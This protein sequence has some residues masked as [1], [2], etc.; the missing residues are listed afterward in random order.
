[1]KIKTI[2]YKDPNA[3]QE[4][5]KSL[6]ETGF[7]V[8][9]NHN[10][11]EDL[12]KNVY[13]DWERF[14]KS[15]DK[16]KHTFD[17]KV[18]TGYFPFKSENSKD[19]KVKDLKEFF[20]V[21]AQKDIPVELGS[22]TWELRTQLNE[23]G[24]TVLDWIQNNLPK[25]ITDKFSESLPS[26]VTGSNDTLFRLLHYPPLPDEVEEGA[27]RAA[28]HEDINLITMLLTSCSNGA[29]YKVGSKTGLVVKDVDGNW[30]EVES[31]PNSIIINCGDFLQSVTEG[32]LK[33]TTHCVKS[34]TDDS[35]K[36]S[37]Y[38]CPL[39]IH[40]RGEVILSG[41]KTARDFLDERLKEIGLK[42]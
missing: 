29:S 18:Q 28:A 9:K 6:K 14:F 31:D 1:M 38:S 34:P 16:F 3:P 36:L 24:I 5:I 4:I 10:I 2:D 7:A 20:H 27:V 22:N 23:L 42:K 30:H 11:S 21:Y 39:F 37:R 33:S 13:L 15:N 40:P 17:P 26:M 35:A 19:S 8:L 12:I 41:T 25:E 32:Y